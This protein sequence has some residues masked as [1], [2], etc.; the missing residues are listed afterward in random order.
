M[1]HLSVKILSFIHYFIFFH[2]NSLPALASNTR[3]LLSEKTIPHP[4]DG[5]GGKSLASSLIHYS[6]PSFPPPP[7]ISVLFHLRT[8]VKT[9]NVTVR[10]IVY[11]IGRVNNV[12]RGGCLFSGNESSD[13]E[14]LVKRYADFP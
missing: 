4:S 14:R 8:S 9:T 11:V 1:Q 12:T 10:G 7:R 13:A 2:K 3:K 5:G 6:W